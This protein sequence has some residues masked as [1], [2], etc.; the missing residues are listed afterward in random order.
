MSKRKWIKAGILFA[1]CLA[2]LGSQTAWGTAITAT[3]VPG[4]P[5]GPQIVDETGVLMEADTNTILYDKGMNQRM[6]PAS[7]TKVMTALVVLENCPDLQASVTF[8]ETGI[9]EVRPDS[10][11]IQAQLGEQLTVEQC[12]YAA[13][14]SSANE[15]CSQLAEYV[16]GT[17]EHFV[18]MMN[19]KAA[20]L[21]CLDTHFTNPNGLH[22][23]NHYTTAY[24]M[25]LIMQ[26]AIQNETFCTID[27]TQAYTIP[28]TNKTAAPRNLSNHHAMLMEGNPSYYEGAFAGK[29][30]NT[31]AAKDTLVTAAKRNGMTLICVVM[32][33][34]NGQVVADTINLMNYGFDQFQQLQIS[35]PA[36]TRSGGFA[37]VPKTVTKE[38]VQIQETAD[39]QNEDQIL[40]TYQW[41]NTT[42]GSAVVEKEEPVSDLVEP[43]SPKTEEAPADSQ[44]NPESVFQN[45]SLSLLIIGA[46][47]ILILLGLALIVIKLRRKDE[48]Y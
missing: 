19:E 2:L 38:Q 10:A 9:Q 27:A 22:D 30:G 6:Y 24:D 28:A 36:Q 40:Q 34:D 15:V 32:R 46:L 8:T 39:P 14:L 48:K 43:V 44:E 29:T 20:E 25:A 13:L 45:S 4:W 21:G 26:A 35:D 12:L 1:L 7:I 47:C 11:N 5:E 17:K 23:E 3:P 16:G 18:E 42:V 41:Q 33:S 37:V 31:A